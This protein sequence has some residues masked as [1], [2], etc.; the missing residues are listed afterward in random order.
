M[1]NQSQIRRE[2]T[3]QI[4]AHLQAGV[5]P[6]VRPW[7]GGPNSGF[8][9]NVISQR[10]YSGIN[11]IIL[12]ASALTHGFSSKWWGTYKQWE[13]LGGQVKRRPDNVPSGRWGTRV[14]FYQPL[15]REVTSENGEKRT[16]RFPLMRTYTLFSLDQ[17]DGVNLDRLRPGATPARTDAQPHY[18][19]AEA[20]LQ[21]CGADLRHGGDRAY[22]CRPV[23]DWPRHTGG[24]YIQL[25]HA[26]RFA[27]PADFITTLA[28]EHCHWSEV[29][30]GWSG[31]YALGELV[32]ELGSV[33]LAAELN[34][35][36]GDHLENHANYIGSWIQELKHDDRALFR[37]AAQASRA[38]DFLLKH[39]RPPETPS[40]L[41]AEALAA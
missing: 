4:V 31:S 39:S 21:A 9:E 34:V 1:S 36:T 38:V 40:D 41:P 19:A 2:I 11:P 22:Y 14:V 13:S 35:P 16:E 6:W 26:D 17:V 28:H 12:Q 15:E 8:P 32:A 5:K 37:A 3:D 20:A 7:T 18:P 33:Y 30:L 29:R 23:G 25:P 10:R 24:D 27:T